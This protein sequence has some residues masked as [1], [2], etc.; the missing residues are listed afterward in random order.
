[1]NNGVQTAVQLHC[2]I[3]INMT[4]AYVKTTR[5][6]YGPFKGRGEAETKA[7][8]LGFM[9]WA[10]WEYERHVCDVYIDKRTMAK[11]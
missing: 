1:M 11:Q 4:G 5:C 6:E 8:A 2:D 9:D 3:I 7:A 10:V